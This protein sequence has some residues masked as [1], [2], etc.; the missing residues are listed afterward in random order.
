MTALQ[1]SIKAALCACLAIS[2]ALPTQD[3]IA[4]PATP[5]QSVA[6]TPRQLTLAD[7]NAFN[8]DDDSL[9]KEQM[10]DIS[11]R[12]KEETGLEK[13]RKMPSKQRLTILRA[14]DLG[15]ASAYSVQELI[16]AG[17]FRFMPVANLHPNAKN[18]DEDISIHKRDG[19]ELE[20]DNSVWGKKMIPA[21]LKFG[22][23]HSTED[24]GADA[25]GTI[26]SW[27]YDCSQGLRS[28]STPFVVGRCLDGPK[29]YVTADF[30]TRWQ[31][32]CSSKLTSRP[33]L[34]NWDSIGIEMAHSTEQKLNYTDLEIINAARLWT[35]V[36]ERAK[37]PDNRLITHGE[38]QG[39]L[40]KDHKSYRTDPEQFDWK[41]FAKEMV[42]LRKKANFQPP[43][44]DPAEGSSKPQ[45]EIANVSH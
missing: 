37:F 2:A 10:Q 35:Y 40:P 22:V 38:I 41:T 5:T 28:S 17:V 8:S 19:K 39:H 7:L 21:E 45:Q 42:S 43:A 16:D 27:N 20:V 11:D 4:Q 44:S 24:G 32:H 23:M 33:G 25:V 12:I 26:D 14:F 30:E 9:S 36:Q 31:R 34:V 15:Q 3:A 18:N 1:N 13:P 6:A 29:I